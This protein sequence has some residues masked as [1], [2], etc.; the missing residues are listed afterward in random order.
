MHLLQPV[1]EGQRG[2]A[3][4]VGGT[5]ADLEVLNDLHGACSPSTC[6]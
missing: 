1:K 3:L 6:E 5:N 2:L 4:H